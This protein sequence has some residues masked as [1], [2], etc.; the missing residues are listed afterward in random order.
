MSMNPGS[1]MSSPVSLSATPSM[2]SEVDGPQD[3]N[4][5]GFKLPGIGPYGSG[6]PLSVSDPQTV[7][8][9]GDGDMELKVGGCIYEIS[10][11]G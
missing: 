10:C 11:Q 8:D 3:T 4:P 9:L 1:R 6:E 7:I 5:D 2:I